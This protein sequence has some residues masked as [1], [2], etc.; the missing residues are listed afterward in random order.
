MV[1]CGYF[2]DDCA[3]DAHHWE[4]DIRDIRPQETGNGLNGKILPGEKSLQKGLEALRS[5]Q[6]ETEWDMSVA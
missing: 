4:I 2:D 3:A 6:E 5:S 1:A